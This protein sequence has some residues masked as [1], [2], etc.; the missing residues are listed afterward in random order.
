MSKAQTSA[1]VIVRG[2]VFY[3]DTDFRFGILYVGDTTT[4]FIHDFE[5]AV[6]L[7]KA[8]STIVEQF[9]AHENKGAE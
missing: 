7:A 5:A 1:R 9:A 3:V 8:A 6:S 4:I 2:D